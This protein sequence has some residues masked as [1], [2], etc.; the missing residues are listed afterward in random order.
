MLYIIWK[1]FCCRTRMWGFWNKKIKF[2]TL[3]RHKKPSKNFQNLKFLWK[4]HVVHHFKTFLIKINILRIWRSK[5]KTLVLNTS[6]K[7]W[8]FIFNARMR[9]NKIETGKSRT[10]NAV[11]YIKIFKL[12]ET[13]KFYN[14]QLQQINSWVTSIITIKTKLKLRAPIE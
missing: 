3:W 12:C 5:F 9:T 10:L 2:Y 7:N 6:K 4:W 1:S 11:S 13:C 8:L 14:N